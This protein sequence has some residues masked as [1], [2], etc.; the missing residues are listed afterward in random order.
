MGGNERTN[1]TPVK[2]LARFVVEER[3]DSP[4]HSGAWK[5]LLKLKSITD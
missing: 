4:G 1:R 3:A 2:H 5:Y